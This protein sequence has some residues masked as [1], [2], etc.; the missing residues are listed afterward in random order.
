VTRRVASLTV[1]ALLVAGCSSGGSIHSAP[2][3]PALEPIASCVTPELQNASGVTVR[4]SDGSPI[5]ALI[6]GGGRTGL[7]FANMSDNN[8][9][10]WLPMAQFLAKAGGYRTA[11]FSCNGSDD[12]P[13]VVD[14]AKELSRRGATKLALLG[15]S[16]GGTFVIAAAKQ[17]GA[18][19]VVETA[20]G[21]EHGT[22][23][24]SV[25]VQKQ[26]RDFLARYAPSR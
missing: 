6:M 1:V 24:L 19:T 15:A 13:N 9:C 10:D 26:I 2:P 14:V 12:V 23:L 11:V 7:V 17:V 16:M 25:P 18:E 22:A 8:L 20:P 5:D 3:S 21:P 4:G